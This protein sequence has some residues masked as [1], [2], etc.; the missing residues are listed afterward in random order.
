M[1]I[2]DVA[3]SREFSYSEKCAGLC[4]LE[5]TSRGFELF[6]RE[7]WYSRE[8]RTHEVDFSSFLDINFYLVDG[9]YTELT[10]AVKITTADLITNTGGVLGLFMEFF[11]ISFYSV[12]SFISQG[13]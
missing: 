6:Q 12:Y 3:N 9:K 8:K 2:N 4:P 1:S 10:Q 13:C 5:C 7:Y 11:S